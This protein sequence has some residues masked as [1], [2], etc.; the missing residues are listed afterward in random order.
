MKTSI[1]VI[2]L[3]ASGLSS[4][5]A[6]YQVVDQGTNYRV[7]QTTT[8]ENGTNTISRYTELATG[9]N[10]QNPTT[11]Q[12]TPSVEQIT[13]L[14]QGGAAATQGQHQVYFPADIYNGVLEVVTPDGRHLNSRPLGVS[15]DDARNTVMIATLKHSSGVLTASNQVTYPDAFNGI[16]ADLVFTYRRGGF[17]SDLVF[18]EQPPT[19][20]TFGLDAENS[21]LQLITEFFN[22]QDPQQIPAASDDWFGLQ[23][24]TLNFGSLTM[25]PGKAFA[26]RSPGS[27][28]P[29]TSSQT[30]VYKSWLHLQGRTFLIEQVPLVYLADDLQQLPDST[31]AVTSSITGALR[32]ASNH[33]QMP[34]APGFVTDTNRIQ[35]AFADLNKRPGVV[36][37]YVEMDSGTSDYT[38]Q[39]GTTYFISGGVYISGTATF[40]GGT[41]L[42]FPEDGSGTMECR[43][44]VCDTTAYSNAM[45]TSENNDNVGDILPWSNGSPTESCN[46]V[47]FLDSLELD[48]CQF[49]YFGTAVTTLGSAVFN[50]VQFS[51]CYLGIVP[52][53]DVTINNALVSSCYI[54]CDGSVN[55]EN[56][57]FDTCFSAADC[58]D[59]YFTNCTFTSM[60]NIV[61]DL[62]GY[63]ATANGSNNAF[64][65]SDLAFGD[66]VVTGGIVDAGNTTADRVGLYWWKTVGPIEGTTIVDLGYH[67]PAVDGNGNPVSTL[68]PGVPDYLSDPSGNGLPDAWQMEY[69]GNLNHFGSDLDPL[70]KTLLYDYT[71]SMNLDAAILFTVEST[72]DYVNYTN[73]TVQL[74]FIGG[75]PY[76]MSYCNYAVFVKGATVTNWLPFVSSNLTVNL[77][78]TDGVY[79]VIVGLSGFLTNSPTWSDYTFTLD[80]VAPVV[81][82]TNPVITSVAGVGSATVIK[83]YLQLQGFATEQL[84]SL[85]YDISN[86]MG[87]A[88]NLNVFVTDRWIDTNTYNFTTNCFQAYD[89]PLATNQ[90]AITLR[91]TDRAGNTTTTNFIVTLDYTTATNPPVTTLIWPQNGMAVSGANITIRGT[92][93]DETGTIVAQVVNGNGT[94][95]TINGLVERNGMFWLE[96]VPLNGTN[97]IC[98]QA[99]DG[100]GKNVTTTNFTVYPSSFTLTIGSTP[101]GDA[102]WQ[103]PGTVS[104]T[105][106]DS[107]A[108]VTVNGVT[109]TVSGN[110]WS[111]S[112]VPNRGQG[113][114]TYD[115]SAVAANDQTA[116]ANASVEM[117]PFWF[118]SSYADSKIGY[119]TV[120]DGHN[121]T[122][123]SEVRIKDFDSSYDS[124]SGLFSYLGGLFDYRV[125][126]SDWI[127]QTAM[128]SDAGSSFS[129]QDS[130]GNSS[131]GPY[132]PASWDLFSEVTGLPDEDLWCVG[133]NNGTEPIYSYHYT[134]N[135]AHEHWH[136]DYG[137][138]AYR[139][140]DATV[141]AATTVKLFTGGKSSVNRQSLWCIQ[142]GATWYGKSL[143]GGWYSVPCK[144]IDKS[145]IQVMGMPVGS[146]GNLWVV[147]PDNSQSDMTVAALGVKHYN[148][149]GLPTK[150]TPRIRANNAILLPDG[151]APNA[152]FCVGQ[153]VNFSV[154]WLPGA[155]PYVSG[156][157]SFHW[158]LPGNY[159][160]EPYRYSASCESYRRNDAWLAYPTT[161]C[162]Y[163]DALQASAC[164]VGMSLQF[165]NGQSVSIASAGQFT[166]V[167]P[168]ISDFQKSIHY[169]QKHTYTLEGHMRWDATFNSTFDGSVGVTQIINC[170]DSTSDY[171]TLGLNLLDGDT[172]IYGKLDGSGNLD[173]QP[174]DFQVANVNSHYIYLS[175]DPYDPFLIHPSGCSTMIANFTDYIRFAPSGGI[176]VTIGTV[177]WQMN[178]HACYGSDAVSPDNINID[179]P[180]SSDAFP[181][182]D[183]IRR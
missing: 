52:C 166:I 99:T 157:S 107:S 95:N 137:G 160:N 118:Y 64:D 145:R 14:P 22:T 108:V 51:N 136:W 161:Q 35:I 142:A 45:F 135:G 37:D 79:D 17:E 2:A 49:S 25:T 116:A 70:G 124:S 21:T 170:N 132:L 57:S 19:P 165:D 131:S 9:L 178:G 55:C 103:G 126:D 56:V 171:Y 44:V 62:Y 141:G 76:Y 24:T 18:R 153:N 69:F 138:G 28:L 155:P 61:Y 10:F 23:D 168:S 26:V 91:V 123:S 34:P 82:I 68:I 90:N 169:F 58:G 42:K 97:Q 127:L 46:G 53:S 92:M 149:E 174:F 147:L 50:D 163:V 43:N 172:E 119:E 88:T 59:S 36:L 148:A 20:D 89:I 66:N 167:R 100:S 164:S 173:G 182:W 41:V 139:D 93:R 1:I 30:P 180:D 29:A 16:K 33:R 121:T 80:R 77:G 47:E 81:S 156:S 65:N 3:L 67:T 74:N 71:N 12:W 73:V 130:S 101:T 128:W 96:N 31:N 109:A 110:S 152:T 122:H 143:V 94:T 38:F 85:S 120:S 40:E 87:M 102:L 125:T 177:N 86:A 84:S 32:M 105:V 83:P 140:M 146:D 179:D 115:A 154:D 112:N 175:D 158:H 114:A 11:G 13:V 111:A 133:D 162:W 150:Y 60:G 159:V 98:I 151:I 27:K 129:Q 63:G 15:Y 78:A 39:S 6:Q 117:G 176:Y 134:A 48:H 7:L 4:I 106:S 54:F 72:N 8:T 5:Q 104:G 183:D 75:M 144:D 181:T 113:T